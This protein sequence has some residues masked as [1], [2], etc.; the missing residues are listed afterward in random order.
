MIKYVVFACS[1][2]GMACTLP[3]RTLRNECVPK[4]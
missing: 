4:V 2:Y 1:F 3:L